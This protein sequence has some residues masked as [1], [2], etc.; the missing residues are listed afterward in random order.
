LR[1]LA[2]KAQNTSDS[3]ADFLAQIVKAGKEKDMTAAEIAARAG[4]APQTI[5]RMKARKSGD[6]GAI[7][8]M[9]AVVGLRFELTGKTSQAARIA[10]GEFFS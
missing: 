7:E 5:S 2:R 6:F 9:A 3:L 8:R 10:R 1:K 4:L